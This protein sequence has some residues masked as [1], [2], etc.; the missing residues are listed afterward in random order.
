MW[1][2][3]YCQINPL[4]E[5]HLSIRQKNHKKTTLRP[6]KY[7]KDLK[8]YCFS[9]SGSVAVSVYKTQTLISKFN[10]LIKNIDNWWCNTGI[11]TVAYEVSNVIVYYPKFLGHNASKFISN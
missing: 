2:V 7:L 9:A 6:S 11:T 3:C 8:S 5:Y 10:T 1:H 4:N